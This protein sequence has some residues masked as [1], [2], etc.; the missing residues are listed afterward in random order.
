[1]RKLL[2]LIL[3]AALSSCS[4]RVDKVFDLYISYEVSKSSPDSSITKQ[5]EI[6]FKNAALHLSIDELEK[7]DRMV[8]EYSA[9]KE[10]QQK[11][12]D[13]KKTMIKDILEYE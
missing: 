1:M 10:I 6:A 12:H 9:S 4:S 8:K 3:V 11:E 13:C 7:L 2:F 5:R